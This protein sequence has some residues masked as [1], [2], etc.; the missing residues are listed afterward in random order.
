MKTDMSILLATIEHKV[1][2]GT[3]VNQLWDTFT[4]TLKESIYNHI[5]QKIAKA[6]DTFPW[7]TK[8]IKQMIKRRDRMYKRKNKS[9]HQGAI[10]VLCNTF[11]LEIGPT[12]TPS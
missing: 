1:V 6:N 12:P 2:V 4:N 9:N 5:P 3:D 10:Q 7:I 11:F 8:L